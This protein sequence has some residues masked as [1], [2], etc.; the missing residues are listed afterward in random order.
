MWW[1]RQRVSGA[2]RRII[3]VT[4]QVVI[5]WFIVDALDLGSVEG[6]RDVQSGAVKPA[7]LVFSKGRVVAVLRARSAPVPL[8]K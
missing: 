2:Y 1:W 8:Q 6:V 4:H 5:D 3:I 7:I